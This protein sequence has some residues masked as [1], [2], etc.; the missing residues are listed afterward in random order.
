MGMQF[1]KNGLF[2]TQ[3]SLEDL[4]RTRNGV[5]CTYQE[6][7]DG[8]NTMHEEHYKDENKPRASIETS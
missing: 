7:I 2:S 8:V 4:V 3:G 5:V 1:T 6:Y